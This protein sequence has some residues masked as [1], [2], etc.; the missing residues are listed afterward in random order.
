V[1]DFL[2]LAYRK[3]KKCKS[4]TSFM[5]R[6]EHPLRKKGEKVKQNLSVKKTPS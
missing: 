1:T 6:G 3:L 2:E 5:G 4:A